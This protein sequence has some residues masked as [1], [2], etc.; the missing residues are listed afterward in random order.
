MRPINDE[1]NKCVFQWLLN[2]NLKGWIPQYV[3]DAA[4]TGV[5]FEYLQ[6]L[7]NHSDRL[8]Q[9]GKIP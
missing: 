2:S 5:M 9:A 7:R 3:I 6:D 1:P 8:R 4:L